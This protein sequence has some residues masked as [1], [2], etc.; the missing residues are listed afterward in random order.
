MV[1]PQNVLHL[2][3]CTNLTAIAL[4]G[5]GKRNQA[6]RRPPPILHL[7]W[8]RKRLRRLQLKQ[9]SQHQ[10]Q[11]RLNPRQNPSPLPLTSLL[12]LRKQKL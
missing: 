4:T 12:R 3:T 7:L 8:W 11:H 6:R 1:S 10:S 5:V 9:Q 2:R